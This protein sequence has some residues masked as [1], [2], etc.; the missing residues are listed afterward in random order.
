MR[1]MLDSLEASERFAIHLVENA[2]Q[3]GMEISEAKFKLREVRQARLQARTVIHAFNEE[4]FQTTIH[5]GSIVSLAIVQ[6]AKNAVDE[7]YFRRIGLFIATLIITLVALL[8]YL[9][10]RRM[11]K[12]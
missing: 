8:L 6:E 3:K 1:Q 11:E 2:E 10:V 12:K 9:Y 7:Y 5:Q 4:Q